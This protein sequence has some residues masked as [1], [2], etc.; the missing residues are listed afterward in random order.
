MIFKGEIPSMEVQQIIGNW[1]IDIIDNQSEEFDFVQLKE[2]LFGDTV[3]I[4]TVVNKGV[5]V[6]MAIE[7]LKRYVALFEARG[8]LIKTDDAHYRKLT[9]EE[10]RA[11]IDAYKTAVSMTNKGDGNE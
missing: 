4:D 7:I 11:A 6:N 9:K 10:M 1:L 8:L 5:S 3:L 2:R